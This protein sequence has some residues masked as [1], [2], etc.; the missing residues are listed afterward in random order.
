MEWL[1]GKN[2]VQRLSGVRLQR[3]LHQ[4]HQM[5]LSLALAQGDECHD[6]CHTGMDRISWALALCVVATLCQ[7]GQE[8]VEYC[9]L[10]KWVA[11]AFQQS[12]ALCLFFVCREKV[13]VGRGVSLTTVQAPV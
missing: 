13:D 12:L 7:V 4:V 3:E 9:F 8:H 5:S 11:D 1:Q 10:H 6:E 2:L